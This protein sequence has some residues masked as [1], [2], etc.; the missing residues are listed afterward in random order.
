MRSR[1]IISLERVIYISFWWPR[2][3]IPIFWK[4]DFK[5]STIWRLFSRR[6]RILPQKVLIKA[7]N[8]PT[9]KNTKSEYPP[10]RLSSYRQCQHSALLSNCKL[11]ANVNQHTALLSKAPSQGKHTFLKQMVTP[12]VTLVR[13]LLG[14]QVYCPTGLE[15]FWIPVT[16]I[17]N[18]ERYYL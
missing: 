4:L 2:T 1:A 12:K 9:H 15:L 18:W 13:A 7:G 14:R 11:T 8:L 16:D 6:L 17:S 10:S 3:I 5:K